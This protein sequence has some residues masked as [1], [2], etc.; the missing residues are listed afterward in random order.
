MK[1]EEAEIV[2]SQYTGEIREEDENRSPE[3]DTEWLY[4]MDDWY[5]LYDAEGYYRGFIA[6]DEFRKIS[7]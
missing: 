3:T 7:D 1:Q 5:P 2:F 4:L 6:D